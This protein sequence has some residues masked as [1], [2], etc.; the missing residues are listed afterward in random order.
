MKIRC[1]LGED[2]FCGNGF[3]YVSLTITYTRLNVIVTLSLISVIHGGCILRISVHKQGHG[4]W[5][6]IAKTLKFMAK[7][8]I[9]PSFCKLQNRCWFVWKGVNTAPVNLHF[10]YF[11][12]HENTVSSSVFSFIQITDEYLYI[13]TVQLRKHT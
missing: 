12:Q 2:T 10:N 3:I 13:V 9:S 4:S 11:L 5:C 1:C 7:I 6:N 8:N